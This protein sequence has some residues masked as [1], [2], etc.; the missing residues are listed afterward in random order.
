M[1]N[2]ATPGFYLL[3]PCL[4]LHCFRILPNLQLGFCKPELKFKQYG[5]TSQPGLPPGAER[6]H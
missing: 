1:G 4:S 5:S 2:S 3:P 6:T